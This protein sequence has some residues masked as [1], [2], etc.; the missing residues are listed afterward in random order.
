MCIVNVHTHYVWSSV[1]TQQLQT[2][3]ISS[4]HHEVDENCALLGYY[5]ASCVNP[6]LATL[7]LRRAQF[8]IT[9]MAE[10]WVYTWKM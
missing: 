10:A 4:F 2:C 6:L 1:L 7:K 3:I 8:S 5:A 9:N